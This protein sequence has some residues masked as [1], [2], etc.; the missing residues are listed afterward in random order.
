VLSMAVV[1]GLSAEQIA[2]R[3]E[4]EPGEE[5]TGDSDSGEEAGAGPGCRRSACMATAG[6]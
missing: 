5:T 2:G 4:A 3:L 1:E 6:R